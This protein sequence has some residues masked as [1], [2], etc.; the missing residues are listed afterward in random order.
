[1]LPLPAYRAVLNDCQLATH[2]CR[3][4]VAIAEWGE[5]LDL[6][7]QRQA[8]LDKGQLRVNTQPLRPGVN[9]VLVYLPAQLPAKVIDM[10]WVQRQACCP[11]MAA[12]VDQQPGTASDRSTDIDIGRTARTAP[13]WL[14]RRVQQQNS[15]LVIRLNQ[16]RGDDANDPRMPVGIGQ[17]NGIEVE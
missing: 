3:G 10:G 14:P 12:V 11:R 15:R 4:W 6:L 9:A 8:Q 13:G 5:T 17:H 1:M 2:P 16:A 7:H